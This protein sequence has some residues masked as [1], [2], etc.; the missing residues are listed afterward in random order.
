M[1]N[2]GETHTDSVICSD[3]KWSEAISVGIAIQT[4]GVALLAM[5]HDFCIKWNELA[6]LLVSRGSQM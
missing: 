5:V 1:A 3:L 6:I 2:C 4:V